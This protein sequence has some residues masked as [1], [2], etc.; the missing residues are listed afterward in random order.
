[1]GEV[2]PELMLCLISAYPHAVS[3]TSRESDTRLYM[4]APALADV[5][6]V[7]ETVSTDMINM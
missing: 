5:S 2:L 4:D 3:Q 6:Q 7:P 1:M